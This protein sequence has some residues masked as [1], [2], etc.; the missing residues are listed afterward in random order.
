MFVLAKSKIYLNKKFL[1]MI[2]KSK[3]LFIVKNFY[4][5]ICKL[6]FNFVNIL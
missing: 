2:V 6:K 1:F 4:T 3:K 5:F